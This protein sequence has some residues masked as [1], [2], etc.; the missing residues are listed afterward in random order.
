KFPTKHFIAEETDDGLLIKPIITMEK[1]K[2]I[3]SYEKKG[4]T[5]LIFP[6]GIDP[7]VLIDKIIEIDG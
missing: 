3:I 2:D 7:Q 1:D 6:K 5:G 4:E